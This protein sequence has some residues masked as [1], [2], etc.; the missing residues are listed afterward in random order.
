L[1][2]YA[3]SNEGAMDFGKFAAEKIKTK[4]DPADLES[5]NYI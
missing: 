2:Y 5:I 3:L 1:S 4:K